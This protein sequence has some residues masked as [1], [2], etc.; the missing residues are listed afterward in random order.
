MKSSLKAATAMLIFSM[1]LVTFGRLS[2]AYS[3]PTSVQ[4][5]ALA[6][7][8][9]VLPLDMASY[10]VKPESSYMESNSFSLNS[11]EG[12]ALYAICTFRNGVHIPAFYRS[13]QVIH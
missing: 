3:E 13:H 6:Y 8:E 12:K 4:D 10:I 2:V 9:N 7:I 11:S 5:K 1:L